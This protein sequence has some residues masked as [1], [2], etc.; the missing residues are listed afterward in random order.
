MTLN[1]PAV[2]GDYRATLGETPVWCYRSR[3][4]LWVDIVQRRLLRYWP[5]QDGR[6]EIRE[7]PFIC[8]A[9]LL[10]E[11]PEH[12]LLI[13]AQGVMLYDYAKRSHS[14]LCG[15]PETHATRPNEAAVAPDGALWF[16]T[17]DVTAKSALGGWYR[18]ATGDTQPVKML[19]GQHVP[20]TLVWHNGHAWFTDT[21]AHCW[22]QSPANVMSAPTLR[23]W[24]LAE[25]IFADGSTLTNNGILINARWGDS[26]LAAY[27]LNEYAPTFLMTLPVPVVQPTSCAF[28][29][30]D[31]QDLYVTSATDGLKKTSATDGALLRYRTSSAGKHVTLFKL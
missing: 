2:I 24:P 22:Y 7:L 9:A 6:I 13:T 18:F 14:P 21:F 28:G 10:T 12:F 29:G 15:W 16:S 17:M 5:E 1:D 4:L 30:A 31:L 3:S 26:C 20:N 11:L 25:D 27:Q 19:G 23:A 8:S